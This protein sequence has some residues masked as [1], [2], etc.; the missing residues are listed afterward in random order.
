MIHA[1][2]NHREK[3]HI[4]GTRN[5]RPSAQE[6]HLNTVIFCRALNCRRKSSV[7][8]DEQ[9]GRMAFGPIS[10][11]RHRVFTLQY[12]HLYS[13]SLKHSLYMLCY[14]DEIISECIYISSHSIHS[15][16]FSINGKQ[17]NLLTGNHPQKF[18]K[19]V[20]S[21]CSCNSHLQNGI[22]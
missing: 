14:Y 21:G 20:S 13:P 5:R 12:I 11:M 6:C 7:H 18:F 2:R 19:L 4:V 15:L 1:A 3:M 16:D 8:T 22:H 17:Y 10:S 9:L